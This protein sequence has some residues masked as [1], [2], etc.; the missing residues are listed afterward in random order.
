M[1]LENFPKKAIA[2]VDLFDGRLKGFG[3]TPK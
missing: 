3:S 2:F 1:Y